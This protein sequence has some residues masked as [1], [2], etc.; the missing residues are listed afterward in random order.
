[1]AV[2]GL[3]GLAAFAGT[4]T[5]SHISLV[6]TDGTHKTFAGQLDNTS[7]VNILQH[8]FL[9]AFIDGSNNL[10]ET[11]SPSGCLRSIQNGKSDFF[12]A[13]STNAASGISVGLARIAFDST[14]KVGT[15][16]SQNVSIT[17]VTANRAT[18]TLTV[19]GKVTNNASDT[20][21][22]P[23]ACIVVR[24]SA[25]NVLITGKASMSDISASANRTFSTTITVPNDS[26]A[27]TVDIWVDGL[28]SGN[29]PTTPQQHTD[30]P[31][32]TGSNK[33]AWTVE[34]EDKTGG[35]PFTNQPKITLEDSSG[36]T[37]TSATDNVTLSVNSGPSGGVLTCT[38][39]PKAAVAG[40]AQ[41]AGCSLDKAGTYVVRA[42]ATGYT[43]ADTTIVITVG[44]AAKTGFTQNPSASTAVN[45][46]FAQQPIAAI[47]DAGGNTITTSTAAI[48]LDIATGTGGAVL[49]GCTNVPGTVA[50]LAV[51]ATCKI[52]FAGTYT[53]K[54]ISTGLVTGTGQSFA[55]TPLA[56]TITF[57]AIA[58]HPAGDFPL[59]LPT[60][61]ASSALTVTLTSTTISVCTVAVFTVTRV[62]AGTCSLTAS[63]AGDATYSA[64]TP[65]VQSFTITS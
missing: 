29:N 17:D 10:V 15:T 56:Q 20:L 27:S 9:V 5:I 31:I 43:S 12:S 32:T 57:A 55:V 63:Q 58:G 6:S 34:P 47:Q 22:S 46:A 52:N 48:T 39:N 14:F 53:L 51:F 26:T 42:T 1:M 50:G 60:P 33:L 21:F 35:I 64:A 25:G 59:L 2:F 18:T 36:T 23:N 16:S 28:D 62:S 41:F 19:A 7:G 30:K 54:A 11:T 61:T 45:A 65:V 13:V 4:C 38:A 3:A 44:V 49:S 24:T 8:N 40:I 37:L